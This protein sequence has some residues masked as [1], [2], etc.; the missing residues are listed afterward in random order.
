MEIFSPGP[1]PALMIYVGRGLPGY[2]ARLVRS[3]SIHSREIRLD[4]SAHELYIFEHTPKKVS[5]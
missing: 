3:V 4:T 1:W 2:G 5:I